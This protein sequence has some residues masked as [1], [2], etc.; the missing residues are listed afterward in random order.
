VPAK[1]ASLLLVLL[2]PADEQQVEQVLQLVERHLGSKE[3]QQ[4]A[5]PQEG[6]Q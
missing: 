4:Q 5:E 1:P 6:A 3:A 2:R